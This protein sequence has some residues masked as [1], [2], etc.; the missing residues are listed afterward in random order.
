M[1][2]YTYVCADGTVKETNGKFNGYAQI[3]HL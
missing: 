3:M 2:I 1:Q